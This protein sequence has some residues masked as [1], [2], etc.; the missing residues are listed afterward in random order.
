[1]S[2]YSTLNTIKW[3]GHISSVTCKEKKQN[4]AKTLRF[5][6]AMLLF[7]SRLL[8]VKEVSGNSKLYFHCFKF[9]CFL[10]SSYTILYLLLV[11][12]IFS[13]F[14]F[15]AESLP[16]CSTDVDCK[17]VS[18]KFYRRICHNNRC[19]IVMFMPP[20]VWVSYL[21]EYTNIMHKIMSSY[22][23]IL[24]KNIPRIAI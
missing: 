15:V 8:I 23:Y 12:W 4:M 16:E 7:L 5:F 19:K 9:P 1:M 24:C 18:S 2:I 21:R 6:Y 20:N 11:T 13:L 17:Q 22:T 10:Y 14:F 3:W